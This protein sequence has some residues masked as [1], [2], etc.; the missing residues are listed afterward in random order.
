MFAEHHGAGTMQIPERKPHIALLLLDAQRNML[1]G[2]TAVVHPSDVMRVLRKL[3]AEARRAGAPVIHVQHCGPPGAVD[4]PGTPGWEIHPSFAPLPGEHIVQKREPS[5]FEGT[6]LAR[7]LETLG[8]RRVVVAGMQSEMCVAATCRAA[9][10]RGY[11]V[12]LARDGHGTFDH[13]ERG[14]SSVIREVN[15]TLA[16]VADVSP[17]DEI[18][19]DF[20]A[21]T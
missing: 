13:G 18:R 11:D 5:A 12:A 16:S 15:A 21:Q 20:V 10:E 3:L 19:F 6:D 4:E 8:V 2:E 17:G 7:V 14:A 9:R 1:E